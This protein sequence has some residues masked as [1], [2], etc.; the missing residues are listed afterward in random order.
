[1]LRR[2]CLNVLVCL[3]ILGLGL[4]LHSQQAQAVPSFNRQ[5][6]L[7]CNACHT[8]FPELTPVGRNFKLNGFT[9]TKHGDKR[10][11]WPPPVSGMV[12]MSFTTMQ[13]PMPAGTFDPSNKG[14]DNLNVPQAVSLFYG[15]R[16]YG[17]HLG[18]LVQG[19]YDGVGNKLFLDNT[20]VRLTAKP[21]LFGKPLVLGLTVN[22][23]P[24]V[25]DVLNTTPAW[26]FPSA[27]P[28]LALTPSAGP[29]IE[30]L[31]GN[32]GGIGGY[33]YW[34]NLIY[35]EAAVY[36]TARKGVTQFLGAGQGTD[37]VIQDVAPYW[38][39]FLNQQWGKHCV[40]VGHFGLVNR[41]LSPANKPVDPSTL[42]QDGNPTGI[43][44]VPYLVDT[45]GPI[46]RFTD[47]GFDAQYQF[48]GKKHIFS[49]Q[50]SYIHEDMRLNSSDLQQSSFGNAAYLGKFK[51]NANYYYRTSDWGSFGGTIAYVNLWGS[52]NFGSP[53]ATG[54][55]A[56]FGLYGPGAGTG[57]RVG[58]PN[59]DWWIFELDYI[60]WWKQLV[61]KITVQY[62][63]YH[64]F[65]GSHTLYDGN[66]G[67]S[68]QT[69]P[70]DTRPFDR[71]NASANNSL[72]LLLWQ[73]F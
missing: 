71:R 67:A 58:K 47:L 46:D 23:N 31:G 50:S 15:G 17:D 20:D 38:R 40:Q 25:S 69:P 72:Y 51:I 9:A 45:R 65:N 57:S 24:T 22:N 6:G 34:N 12:Q 42:D 43:P 5:T 48:I 36:R 53:D 41:N 49:V 8:M 44:N 54:A 64:H 59:S 62:T 14:N 18:A 32:V 27:A 2:K 35:A 30:G 73:T 29:Q 10:Y 37:P 28:A 3:V 19:T 70:S 68:A 66:V 63:V 55:T 26:G 39:V 1:M 33:F 16:I 52:K 60:P 61:T 56:P 7:E 13:K 11:E 21:E 4:A